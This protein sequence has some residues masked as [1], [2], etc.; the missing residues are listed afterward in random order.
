MFEAKPKTNKMEFKG[1]KGPWKYDHDKIVN[2]NQEIVETEPFGSSREQW[3]KRKANRTL[4]AAAPELL[5]ALQNIVK[6]IHTERLDGQLGDQLD[7]AEK[8]IEKALK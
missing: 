6:S 1:T 5:E 4:I 3:I 7:E 2:Y 8:A